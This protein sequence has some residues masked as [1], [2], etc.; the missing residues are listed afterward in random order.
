[1]NSCRYA[2]LFVPFLVV[3]WVAVLA[4]IAG[5]SFAQDSPFLVSAKHTKRIRARLRV[6]VL[7]PSNR[8]LTSGKP[9]VVQVVETV[10]PSTGTPLNEYQLVLTLLKHNGLKVLSDSFSPSD[11]SSVTT[12]SMD[13][14][15]PGEYD[16]AAELQ[17]NGTTVS[18]PRLIRIKK[19]SDAA[20]SATPTI[21]ATATPTATPST[22]PS[23]TSTPTREATVTATATRTSTPTETATHTA[24]ATV[25][26]TA[27]ST[28]TATMTATATASPTAT[29]TSTA[30]PTAT[31]T[32]TATSTRTATSTATSTPTA[33][34]TA[35]ATATPTAT[36][37]ATATSTG[38]ATSTATSTPTATQTAT[39]TA[40][41][42]ATATVT[43]TS[44]GTAT[45]TATSTPT[46]THTA[47]AT[48][49]PTATAT[50]TATSTGTATSTATSTPTA[51]QTATATATPTA[52]ATVTAFHGYGNLNCDLDPYSHS[53]C[54]R[55]GDAHSKSNLHSDS[56]VTSTPTATPTGTPIINY[57]NGFGGATCQDC[58][59][60]PANEPIW[61]STGVAA[62]GSAL[63][64]LTDG[65]HTG[66]NIWYA[67]PV[68]VQAFTTT[69]TFQADCSA[70]PTFCGQGF[71]F[72]IIAN[73]ASNP[74]YTVC[75]GEPPGSTCGYNY[76]GFA[77]PYLSWAQNCNAVDN[78]NCLAIDEAIVKFDLYALTGSGHN[79]TNYCQASTTIDGTY[80][81][82]FSSST[83]NTNCSGLD[84]NMAPSGINMQSGDIFKVTLTYDGSNL[85][86]SVTDTSTGANFTHTY[87][88]IN[89]PSIVGANTAFVGFGGST[90]AYTMNAYLNSWT[91]TVK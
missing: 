20:A 74:Y 33:T 39:A 3:F 84:L 82:N 29:A 88:G 23:P 19:R 52:T 36:A 26:A 9:Q 32:A 1:M 51:T 61:I 73:N 40:T 71:G 38:T 56:T 70:D 60:P 89:L 59:P 66:N 85:F 68:N 22:D 45:S 17:Q 79:L 49:T 80:P 44:T 6:S 11:T 78:D 54:H 90:G 48:A 53:D 64:I 47:T 18:G 69:F 35:T 81:Q 31:A 4:G 15:A 37:T 13:T 24:T 91:Y 58:A 57:P 43:A 83:A 5:E 77:G 41:P 8:I 55:K 16:L 10:Q 46:A 75:P 7:Y 12:L 72:M 62:A 25:T 14:V 28:R 34:Q 27:T 76:T 65:I 63:G 21:T 86:E 67:T 42:T 87:T 2:R 50:V 30:T